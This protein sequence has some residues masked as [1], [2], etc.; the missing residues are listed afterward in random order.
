MTGEAKLVDGFGRTHT[1]LRVSVTDRCNL[2]CVY[3]MP[4]DVQ[5]LPREEILSFEEI[6]AAVE[7]LAELGVSKVRLTGGEPL[8]RKGLPDLVRM[9]KRVRGLTDLGLTT[10]GITLAQHAAD[11]YAA[12]LRTAN[13][14]LDT[15]DPGRF[16]ELARRDGVERV[17]EGLRAS[18]AAGFE[19]IKVNAVALRGYFEHD[20]G[21]LALFCKAHGFE[22]RVIETM[23]IGADAWDRSQLVPATEIL[24]LIES[25]AG[26]LVPAHN[27]DPHAPASEFEYADGRGRVGIIAS[28]TRPFCKLCNRL[29]LT[30]D[31]KL[32]NCLFS[33]AETDVKPFLRPRLDR[34]GFVAA[35]RSC[36]SSKGPGHEINLASF[37]KPTRTMHAIG[38]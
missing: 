25:A 34:A 20:A 15:L 4:E 22:F 30:A 26:P 21:P 35:A 5:F 8:L 10:N 6:T 12:G 36:V 1:N 14:S 38:G 37:V 17:I 33:Q 32:R 31:G 24:E 2:R 27:Y 28:V 19:R 29:R 11:L 13:V 18:K 9:L 7:T 23:P 16:R 3:C